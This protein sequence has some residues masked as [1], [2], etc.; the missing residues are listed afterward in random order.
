MTRPRPAPSW[1]RVCVAFVECSKDSRPRKRTSLKP[2]VA[3][4][5]LTVLLRWLRL[6]TETRKFYQQRRASLSQQQAARDARVAVANGQTYQQPA[7]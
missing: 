7:E 4:K 2:H 3:S 1:V 6:P 5:E